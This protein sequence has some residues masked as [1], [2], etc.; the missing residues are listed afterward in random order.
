MTEFLKIRE[1]ERLADLL[2]G[3]EPERAQHDSSLPKVKKP[4]VKK[5]GKS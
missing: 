1:A 2:S 5:N 4:K 3:K